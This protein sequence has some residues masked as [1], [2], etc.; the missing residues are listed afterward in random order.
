MRKWTMA[1]L[2]GFL[3]LGAASRPAVASDYKVIRAEKVGGEGGFDYVY[4]DSDGRKLYIPRGNRVMVYDLDSLKEVGQI[5]DAKGV[6]GAIV[7]P[8]SHHGFS[9]SKP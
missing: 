1:A 4:A 2:A 8:A 5:A 3:A 9:S 6:H 7:D